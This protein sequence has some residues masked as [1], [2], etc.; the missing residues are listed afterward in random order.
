MELARDQFIQGVAVDDDIRE[1][2]FL[3][4]PGALVDAVR[5]V[6][7]LESARK[8]CRAVPSG[9]KNKSVSVVTSSVE[10]QKISLE[11]SELKEIV[12]GMN[13]KIRELE[14]KTE[15]KFMPTSPRR[16]DVIC[17][18]CHKRGHF[19]R[20][21]PNKASENGVRG[22]PWASQSPQDQ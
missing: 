18:S 14:R 7:H 4:Q 19:A 1:K 17:Y 6:R 12:L 2:L 21:C 15:S 16:D 9:N 22:L 10:N 11:I 5:T 8:A 20:E 3:S 13:D